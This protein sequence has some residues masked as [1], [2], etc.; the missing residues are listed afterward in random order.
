MLRKYTSSSFYPCSWST[1]YTS[2]LMGCGF[3]SEILEIESVESVL[4]S[5]LG[6]LLVNQ[7]DVYAIFEYP[8]AIMD[9]HILRF[10]SQ[11]GFH[12][13]ALRTLTEKSQVSLET[14][15]AA[16]GTMARSLPQL[17]FHVHVACG[18]DRSTLFRK[19]PSLVDIMTQNMT[20]GTFGCPIMTAINAPSLI[21]SSARLAYERRK[22][23]GAVLYYVPGIWETDSQD[24]GDVVIVPTSTLDPASVATLRARSE[25]ARKVERTDSHVHSLAGHCQRILRTREKSPRK[26]NATA[27]SYRRARLALTGYNIRNILRLIP[28]A[29]IRTELR[30]YGEESFFLPEG[31]RPH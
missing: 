19:F 14:S 21:T 16:V 17:R 1:G 2:E 22:A 24:Q 27:A 8:W 4:F 15:L 23:R 28:D 29:F 5:H 25:D 26:S 31:V 10:K 7:S 3:S 30:M 13:E 12:E 9:A 11:T 6:E 18:S 20:L